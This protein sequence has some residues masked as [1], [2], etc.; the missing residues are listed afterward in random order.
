MGNDH[1]NRDPEYSRHD[2][3]RRGGEV[4]L[5]YSQKGHPD[6][7]NDQQEDRWSKFSRALFVSTYL[8]R[9]F[10]FSISPHVATNID[11]YISCSCL[12]PGPS[13]RKFLTQSTTASNRST[14]R[15]SLFVHSVSHH[16]R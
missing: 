11:W 4:C 14:P 10:R 15:S 1:L 3:L 7:K 9:N 13:K 5:K 6:G 12:I 8:S 16:N 2:N